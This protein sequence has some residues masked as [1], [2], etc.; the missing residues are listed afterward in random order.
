MV[1][2]VEPPGQ[3]GAYDCLVGDSE[4]ARRMRGFDWSPTQVG[5]VAGWP[6]SLRTAVSIMLASGYPMAIAWG[7]TYTWFYNDGYRPVLGSTKHPGAL[8]KPGREVWVEI[9]DYVGGLFDRVVATGVEESR[10]DQLFLLERHGFIEECYFD[11][12]YSPIR[13]E[14]GGVGGV[15]VTCSETTGRVIGER[16]L[17]TLRDLAAEASE[18][19]AEA[20]AW[21]GVARALAGNP[22]DLPFAALY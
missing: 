7:P 5:P 14:S 9:W 15:L 10:R 22:Q 6:Q 4:M 12:S 20:D 2:P 1:R 17:R 16:R 19:R 13:D 3:N 21:K 18:A 8:G 11:F